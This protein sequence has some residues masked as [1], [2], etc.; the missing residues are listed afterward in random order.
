MHLF[1][2]WMYWPDLSGVTQLLA[3]LNNAGSG[4]TTNHGDA[5]GVKES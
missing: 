3:L 5:S 4:S 2:A 1:L